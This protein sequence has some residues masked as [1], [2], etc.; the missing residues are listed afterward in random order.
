MLLLEE[1][2]EEEVLERGGASVVCWYCTVKRMSSTAM[3][4]F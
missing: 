1:V 3:K 4:E 2:G